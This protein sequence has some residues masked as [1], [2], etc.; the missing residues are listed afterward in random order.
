MEK[1][2]LDEPLLLLDG[3]LGTTLEEERG[4]CFTDAT[5]LWSSHLLVS[6]PETLLDV[7]SGY[8][9]AGADI[10]LTATYQASFHGFEE[11]LKAVS[12]E[13]I[14]KVLGWEAGNDWPSPSLPPCPSSTF[15]SCC[16]R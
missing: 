1:H 10:L 14:A 8:V 5:P 7:H 15:R 13:D 3:G 2:L 11:T 9:S 16:S 4:I 6:S 12:N